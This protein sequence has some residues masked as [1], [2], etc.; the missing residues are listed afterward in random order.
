MA[1]EK[2]TALNSRISQKSD[3]NAN[4]AKVQNSFVPMRG[5][6][7]V[8]LD[9]SIITYSDNTKKYCPGYKIGDGEHTL[10]QLAFVDENTYQSVM[11]KIAELES[12]FNGHT[13]NTSIHVSD[14][15]RQFWDSKAAIDETNEILVLTPSRTK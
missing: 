12:F 15:D 5:E 8:Y 3:Y 6:G 13:N 1:N 10:A 2:I 9:R 14:E 11:K 7:I 4:W